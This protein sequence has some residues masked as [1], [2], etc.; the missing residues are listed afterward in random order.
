MN[1]MKTKQQRLATAF[2]TSAALLLSAMNA[3]AQSILLTANDFVLLGGTAVTVAGAG[4]DVFSNGNVGSPLSISGFPPATVVNGTTI[5]GGAIVNQAMIDLG[6]ARNALSAMPVIPANNLTGQDLGGMTL[7]PGVYKFDVA[8]AITLAG[9]KILTLDAQGKNNVVWVFN[10]GTS[11]TTAAGSQIKFINLG[12]N[13]GADNG[14]FWNAGTAITFGATNVIAGNYIAGTN[15]TFGTT[16]PAAGSGSGRA[17]AG[18][19]VSFDGAATMDKLGAPGN[20]DLAGGL[21]LDGGVIVSSGYVLLSADGTY[22]QG[23][24]P[25][26]P[27]ETRVVLKPGTLYNTAGVSVD[28]TSADTALAPPATLTVFKTIATLTGNNSYTGGTIVDAGSLTASTA[29]LPLNGNVSL[30]DSNGTGTAGVI[31]FNQSSNGTF[32]GAISGN[33]SVTKQNTGTLTL[34]GN[35]TYTGATLL[36]GGTLVANSA[37]LPVNSGVTMTN[38]SSLVLDQAATGTFGGLVAGAGSVTKQGDGS[39]TFTAANTYDGGTTVDTGSLVLSGAG[40]LGAP[41]GPLAV[42]TAILDLGGTSQTV[43]AVTLNNGTISNGMLNGSSYTST[44]GNVSASLGGPGIVFTNTSGN[45]TLTGNNSYT[46]GT[47]ING[48]IVTASS[49]SLPAAQAVTIADGASL[50]FSEPTDGTFSGATSGA[51]SVEKLGAGA[52]TLTGNNLHSGGTTVTSGTLTTSGNGTFGAADGALTVNGGTL[53]LGAGNRTAGA[54]VLGGGTIRNGTL[55]GTSYTSTGGNVSASLAGPGVVFT[56][57]SGT[58]SLTGNNTYTGGTVINGGIVSSS[59]AHLPSD[60]TVTIATGGELVLNDPTSGTYSGNLTGSGVFRKQGS[61]TLTFALPTTTAIEL[62]AGSLYS[63]SSIGSLNIASGAFFGGNA[64]VTGNVVNNG[65]LSP[66]NSPGQIIVAGN[67]TQL[68]AGTLLIEFA[69]LTSFDQLVV[70]GTASLAG[71]LQI[72]VLGSYNPAGKTFDIL[73]AGGGVSGTFAP[74]TGSAALI[75]TVNYSANAVTISFVQVPFSTFAMTPNQTAIADA[76]LLSP[77]LTDALNLVPLASQLPAA[78]NAL[79]PQGY[80]VWSD[81]AFARTT[82]LGERLARR[83]VAPAG[84]DNYYLEVGQ[85]RSRSSGDLDVGTTH[86]ST[87]S[88]LVGGDYR[89]NDHFAVGAFFQYSE[90][91]ADLGTPGSTTKILGHMPG[92]RAVWNDGPWFANAA[93]AY[94]FDDYKA[95][96]PIN[97]PGTSAVAK[98][99]THGNQWLADISAGR[100]FTAGP[101][102]LSPFVGA[103]ASGWKASG[104]NE[105][106]AGIN[107]NTVHR[108]SADS[109]KSQAGLQ[110]A[111]NLNFGEVVFSPH[112]R[113]AWLHEFANDARTIRSTFGS[114]DYAITTRKPELDSARLSAGFDLA[115]GP[116]TS[117]YADYAVQTGDTTRVIGEW[118]AGISF[119]F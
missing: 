114:V 3:S 62:E 4:P 80:E 22:T 76:A 35:N 37:S 55:T 93:V 99:R 29:T 40:K 106:G 39:L 72:D 17:L 20:G 28:G 49:T 11:L 69:S 61:G 84:R 81:A 70:T 66:G 58:T 107:N 78:L 51:G 64:T 71:T 46:G 45:T 116:R 108:Q 9:T 112:V 103:Q 19:I 16:V 110:A 117:I 104:F 90:T 119:S 86:Y 98:S 82:S 23:V 118:S 59:L 15:I 6:T 100:R 63:N 42:N 24:A 1:R 102:A 8:A 41:T 53:D 94:S 109:L 10:I 88:G 97:F 73:T 52:L 111:L 18:A 38:A 105:S 12:T 34:T 75:S 101:L 43:G 27:G 113:A 54:V 33:G 2:A 65:T 31:V 91:D 95:T 32:G 87:N 26:P 92:L 7:A 96:R 50:H 89:I 74:V 83:E 79:S 5:L 67:F 56:N 60:Q 48:G 68:P 77:G 36:N 14:L 25:L 13:L 30:I 47:V 85:S 57:T 44:G 115:V 21:A